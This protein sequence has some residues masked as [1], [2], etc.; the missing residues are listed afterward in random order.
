MKHLDEI[1]DIQNFQT[2]TQL[3]SNRVNTY[4]ND[5]IVLFKTICKMSTRDEAP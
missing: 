1:E 3:E 4:L 5:A 2:G